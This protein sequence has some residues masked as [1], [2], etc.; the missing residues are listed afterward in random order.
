MKKISKNFLNKSE[1]H[2]FAVIQ[3]NI[4]PLLI[5]DRNG[6]KKT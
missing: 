3:D 6:E 4:K 2:I 1:T 5:I